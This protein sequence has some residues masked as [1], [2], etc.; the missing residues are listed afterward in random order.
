MINNNDHWNSQA[1][2]W[3]SIGPP[4]RPSS[5]DISVFNDML[6]KCS[7]KSSL[8]KSL[9]LGVTSEIA[10]IDYFDK[11][12]LIA[13]DRNI[14]MINQ[15]S[16]IESNNA[17][18]MI[19][20]DWLTM[21][22]ENG[23]L[24]IVIGDGCFTQLHYPNDYKNVLKNISRLLKKNGFVIFRFFTKNNLESEEHIINEIKTNKIKNFHIFKFRLAMALQLD[25]E[26]GVKLSDIWNTWESLKINTNILAA[27][28]NCDIETI[29]SID[30]YKNSKARYSFPSEIELTEVLC[31]NFTLIEHYQPEYPF[32]D[33]CPIM[34]LQ[35][36]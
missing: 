16:A 21:P 3:A 10:T 24:N 28:L 34:L 31:E 36:K 7:E 11:N 22:F 27:S 26:K 8:T 23:S 12:H 9:L 15:L 20:G 5:E 25:V 13:I 17:K 29:Q 35:K 6:N 4:L 33:Q 19:Q 32:G 30:S 1:T 18:L 14:S 2:K